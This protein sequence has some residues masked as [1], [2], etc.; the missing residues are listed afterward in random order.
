MRNEYITAQWY[1][2]GGER[3]GNKRKRD[4]DR[5][6]ERERGRDRALARAGTHAHNAGVGERTDPFLSLP[7]AERGSCFTVMITLRQDIAGKQAFEIAKLVSAHVES[8]KILLDR[9]YRQEL[10]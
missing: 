10:V 9:H 6:R 2:V 5:E 7:Q 3:G 1:S 4:R 8:V